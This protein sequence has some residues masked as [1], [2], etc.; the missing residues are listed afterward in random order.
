MVWIMN[1]RRRVHIC[2]ATGSLED[3]GGVFD[4]VEGGCRMFDVMIF[5][6]VME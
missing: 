4:S 1:T 3:S 5:W 2:G 6:L